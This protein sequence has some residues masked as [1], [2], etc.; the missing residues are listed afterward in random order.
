MKPSS[1]RI[2]DSSSLTLEA[3]TSQR[4]LP[5]C[6]AL[7]MRVRKSAM[8]SVIVIAHP[9]PARLGHAREVALQG[10]LAETQAAQLELADVG[11]RTTAQFA[12]VAVPD[13]EL[14]GPQ[15]LRDL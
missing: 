12:A 5:A 13:A 7:R 1:W 11:A 8:G 6:T 4:S 10:Q 9:L 2:L 15:R 14:R 3:G